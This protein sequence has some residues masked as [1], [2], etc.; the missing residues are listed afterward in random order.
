MMPLATSFLSEL[1]Q[2]HGAADPQTRLPAGSSWTQRQVGKDR[3]DTD[4]LV[5]ILTKTLELPEATRSNIFVTTEELVVAH[6]QDAKPMSAAIWYP[7]RFLRSWQE[8]YEEVCADLDRRRP[9]QKTKPHQT[10][11]RVGSPQSPALNAIRTLPTRLG[12]KPLPTPSA[13]THP[14]VSIPGRR[15]QAFGCS[16]LATNHSDLDRTINRQSPA[17]YLVESTSDETKKTQ[18]RRNRPHHQ[19]P[20][21]L[22]GVIN[23]LAS[24]APYNP[25]SH[26]S[27]LF[28]KPLLVFSQHQQTAFFSARSDPW[29]VG[30]TTRNKRI[31][32]SCPVC[33]FKVSATI[34]LRRQNQ[35]AAR[36]ASLSTT[37]RIRR[38]HHRLSTRRS[39]RRVD[40]TSCQRCLANAVAD[41]VT[42]SDTLGPSFAPSPSFSLGPL[43][44]SSSPLR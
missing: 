10:A 27:S 16:K 24:P 4:R 7:V 12:H 40:M 3:D 19:T 36:A 41:E 23:C 11:L 20:R 35:V 33:D 34:N 8:E 28:S 39:L 31:R 13:P 15:S 5:K 21:P 42:H 25:I 22:V 9:H 38:L 43:S 18:P 32:F 14:A 26:T 1:Y 6:R 44:C 29:T 2:R 30:Q 37:S 17:T